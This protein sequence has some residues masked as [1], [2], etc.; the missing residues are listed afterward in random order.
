MMN[1]TL[2]PTSE[3]G[4]ILQQAY[5]Y[6]ASDF[7]ND[8]LFKLY[9]TK[10][11]VIP[12]ISIHGDYLSEMSDESEPLYVL[13]VN[14]HYLKG[15]YLIPYLCENVNMNISFLFIYTEFDPQMTPDKINHY[16]EHRN[17]KAD[18][19]SKSV[20]MNGKTDI[21]KIYAQTKI[22]LTPSICEETFCRV[23]YEGM[24]LNIPILSS[25]NGNLKYL[26]KEYA[27]FLKDYA[28]TDWKNTI[29][30]VYFSREHSREISREKMIEEEKRVQ[31]QLMEKV[32]DMENMG[33]MENMSSI[34]LRPLYQFNPKHVGII[35]PWADQGLGIQARD[36][37]IT[38]KLLGYTPFIFSFKPYHA[39]HE[40]IRLQ[41][42][43]DEWIYP[44]VH[45]STHYREEIDKEEIADFIYHNHISTIVV[46]EA[47]F[48]PI[49][50]LV[51]WIKQMKV[52]TVLVVNI[53]C[54]RMEDI[55]L[56]EHFD[57][58]LMNNHASVELFQT[59]F[60]QKT[61]YIG[62]HLNHPY[63]NRDKEFNRT[64][65]EPIRFL[66]MG[67]LNSISR[68]NINNILDVFIQLEKENKITNWELN[69]YI[70]GVEYPP[71]LEKYLS[72]EKSSRIKI[73]VE[74][75]SY[76]EVV[77]IYHRND[78]FIHMGT[79]EGLGLGFYE[80]LYTGTPVLTFDWSPNHEII[81][82]NVNGW[83]I[84]CEYEKMTD[85][86]QGLIHKAVFIQTEFSHKIVELCTDKTKTYEIIQKTIQN[87]KKYVEESKQVY[88]QRW[89][90]VLS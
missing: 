74:N 61:L 81:Q 65:E 85:N 55:E 56:H 28:Y 59:F 22:L 4:L 53:E 38:F 7:V 54:V 83:C 32:R 17:K 16:V 20:F 71:H 34:S 13:L 68:K 26:L 64:V 79:H 25:S 50:H 70:Q 5:T 15:G 89:L 52:K 51:Q 49:F 11:D 18:G 45:Y 35:V 9:Q 24:K 80:S 78:I 47:T 67:G 44:N 12:T 6:V 73:H 40:N 33:D 84:P 87:K 10:L 90:S 57:C 60:P 62:F 75:N 1:K 19:K 14:C 86:T 37:Y 27:T 63:F 8:I 21:S 30:K 66:C 39:T 41:T 2:K 3:F 72:M 29:E 42:C 69:V 36:Y 76:L 77:D 48:A 88:E 31:C 23:A 82:N 58:L 43:A 46:I